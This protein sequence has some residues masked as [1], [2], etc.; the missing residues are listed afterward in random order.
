M[1]KI[2]NQHIAT[3][4]NNQ[5]DFEVL[6]HQ[7]RIHKWL[8]MALV[9]FTF[10]LGF[11]Y[12][13]RTLP[14][15]QSDVL[16][17][18]D[19]SRSSSGF[20]AFSNTAVLGGFGAGINNP[21]MTQMALIQSRF[22]LEPV[23]KKLG[24]DILVT[25][26]KSSLKEWIMPRLLSQKKIEVA[27]FE[28]PKN[29]SKN[30]FIISVDSKNHIK[31]FSLSHTLILQGPIH[32]LLMD[33]TKTIK[34]QIKHIQA[35]VG[36]EFSLTK[37][38]MTDAVKSMIG[39]IGLDEAGV[40]R[41][42]QSTGILHVTFKGTNPKIVAA[43]LNTIAHVAKEKD[44]QKKA[45]EASQT[46]DFLEKQL[47]LT[48]LDLERAEKTL[49]QYKSKSGKIDIKLQTQ[50]LLN[51]LSGLDHTLDKLRINKIDLLQKY[52]KKH[53]VFI[54]IQTKMHEMYL[55]RSKLERVLKTLPASDQIAV[56]L[57][58]DVKVKENLYLILL[59]KIEELQVIKA[60]T[61]SGIRILSKATKSD[62]PIRKA[63]G[64]IYLLSLF[65]GFSLSLLI[66]FGRRFISPRIEDP[67]WSEHHYNI[68]NL[69][70]IPYCKAQSSMAVGLDKTH[71]LPLL[72]HMHPRDLS[73]EALRSLRT[74]LQVSL[75][76]A[77]N[78]VVSILGISP[79]VGKSFVSVNLAYLLATA[80]KRVLLM[81]A[82]LRRGT[83]HKYM[84]MKPSPGLSDFLNN[85]ATLDE[86]IASPL[87]ENLH[88]IP[89]GS[90]PKDPSELLMGEKFKLMMGSL[91]Q[92]YDLV[93]IDT[94]PVL[95]VT[96]AV[97][98]GALSSVNYLVLGAG[99]HQPVEIE[100][101]LKSLMSSGVQVHG[102]IFNFHH[103]Q[104]KKLSYG[105]YYRYSYSNYYDDA[106]K[107]A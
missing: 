5:L 58:R 15:Y 49:N 2:G 48:K 74:S 35:P 96:D 23:V 7:L 75:M 18:V 42:N 99:A 94:A 104:S 62:F 60:G 80:G 31:L 55:Q 66:I 45:Q 32:S 29:E 9:L 71:Q 90:Y 11:F 10:A 79:G 1:N 50:Y 26:K 64:P 59:N 17:Q 44:A 51:Q 95:L 27:L 98:V 101:A 78:N 103:S 16:L 8:V 89:R 81:D 13:S 92:Q 28:L 43:I 36:S 76:N 38:S 57:L 88:C 56:N 73:I 84:N 83:V 24:L 33:S 67:N 85:T 3:S 87:I 14:V 30:A 25:P 37:S 22:I 52:T 93:I 72:S 107:Q 70:I 97:I 20:S 6:L 106:M 19:A 47:P 91:S 65:L 69:A 105:K 77:K 53:P 63:K 46:L 100:A 34:L 41:I 4:K 82:D 21:L 86:I 12:S 40:G 54:A 39:Q 61:I 68:P 102:S